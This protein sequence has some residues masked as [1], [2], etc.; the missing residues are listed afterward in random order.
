MLTGIVFVNFSFIQQL[1]NIYFKEG[2]PCETQASVFQ[3]CCPLQGHL[4]SG[5]QLTTTVERNNLA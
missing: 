5:V 1:H 3:I 2:K 4:M